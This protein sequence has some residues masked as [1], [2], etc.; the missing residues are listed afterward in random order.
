MA[1]SNKS[2]SGPAWIGGAPSP[3]A[4]ET[5]SREL[6][7]ALRG[8]RSQAAFCRRIGRRSNVAHAWE[9]GRRQPRVSEFLRA[10]ARVGTDVGAALSAF[11]GA[12]APGLVFSPPFTAQSTSRL[13]DALRQGNSVADLAQRSGVGR[14]ALARWIAG[15][16]EPRLAELLRLIDASYRQALVFISHFV[17]PDSL[18]SARAEWTKLRAQWDLLAELPIGLAILS[19]LRVRQYLECLHHDDA[20]VAS[21]VGIGVAEAQAALARLHQVGLVEHDGVRFRTTPVRPLLIPPS[22]N[23]PI[24]RHYGAEA[25]KAIGQSADSLTITFLL[26]LDEEALRSL[27]DRTVQFVRTEVARIDPERRD[28]TSVTSLFFQ[29][30]PLGS[31]PSRGTDRERIVPPQRNSPSG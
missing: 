20:I 9:S 21:L 7:R 8:R 25:V 1:R 11:A 28:A 2:S 15:T 10:S 13:V 3:I 29:I 30:R 17:D 6:A 18:P 23:Q 22:A 14:G 24:R 5:L 31:T 16:S 12:F 4:Y 26:P 27:R 19:A